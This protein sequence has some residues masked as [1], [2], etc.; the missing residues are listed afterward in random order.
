MIGKEI[1][2]KK[3]ISLNE[4]K[5][6]LKERNKEGELTYEQ[7]TTYD[8]VKKFSKLTAAK[9]KKIMKEL[10]E[11]ETIEDDFAL[12]I[13][14]VLPENLEILKVM[15][16]KNSKATDEDLQKALDVTKKYL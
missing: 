9:Q 11:I 8:Y 16:H 13:A 3:P 4:I 2:A 12:R 7:K 14:D 6:I 1:I 10:S 15:A 5:D